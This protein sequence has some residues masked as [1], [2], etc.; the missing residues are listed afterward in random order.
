MKTKKI[1]TRELCYIGIFTAILAVCAQL[2]IPMPYGVPMTLQTFAIP[3]AGIV[4]G[5]RNGV[6]VTLVYL[7]L[8][9]AGAPVFAGF[10]GGIGIIFG[11]TGGFIL[12]FPALAMTAGIGAGKSRIRLIAWLTVG[13]IINFICGMLMFSFVTSGSIGVSFAYVVAPFIPAAIVKI[14]LVSVLGNRMKQTL[15]KYGVSV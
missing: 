6:L 5:A 9:A 14:L 11:R 12:S 10:T 8:G 13:A 7:L 3:L 4:L 1:T 15:Q 2:S